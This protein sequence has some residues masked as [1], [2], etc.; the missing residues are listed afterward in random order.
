MEKI[1]IKRILEVRSPE[2]PRLKGCRQGFFYELGRS[3]EKSR[4]YRQ[5][6]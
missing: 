5:V 1:F 3:D 2:R 6:L 4:Q